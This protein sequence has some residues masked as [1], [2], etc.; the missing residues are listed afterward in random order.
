MGC[1]SQ[2]QLPFDRGG[3]HPWQ[4]ASL[5]QGLIERKASHPQSHRGILV[6]CLW[7]VEGSKGTPPKTSV[8]TSRDRGNR[9]NRYLSATLSGGWS[10]SGHHVLNL[11]HMVA[12]KESCYRSASSAARH[13][14]LML[15]GQPLV[16]LDRRV[17]DISR[18]T[19]WGWGICLYSNCVCVLCPENEAPT[20]FGLTSFVT[21]RL[22]PSPKIYLVGLA[23]RSVS[24]AAHMA[25]SSGF[26]RVTEVKGWPERHR[27]QF[28]AR[29]AY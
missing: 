23:W 22:V 20:C 13:A 25:M 15:A 16:W 27:R 29:G 19:W 9:P 5:P 21:A 4:T 7:T 10:W 11:Q 1:C 17:Q 28:P 18:L 2:S 14:A 26:Y 3:S 12:T 24:G 6:A 8:G